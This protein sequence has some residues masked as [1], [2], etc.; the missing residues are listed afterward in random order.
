MC[1]TYS[2]PMI[3]ENDCNTLED[4]IDTIQARCSK[5]NLFL[6]PDK[7]CVISFSRNITNVTSYNYMIS[8]SQNRAI[9]T[10]GVNLF[11]CL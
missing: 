3:N 8:R 6:N 9:L 2:M 11:Y 10:H 7:C 4:N 5:N 1:T